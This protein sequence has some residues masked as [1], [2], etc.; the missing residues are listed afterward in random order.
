MDHQTQTRYGE[1]LVE[2]FTST[3]FIAATVVSTLAHAAI[4]MLVVADTIEPFKPLS[5]SIHSALVVVGAA[6]AL[7][8]THRRSA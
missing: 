1:L 7:Y 8:L 5:V 3:W 6:S 2:W 4:V